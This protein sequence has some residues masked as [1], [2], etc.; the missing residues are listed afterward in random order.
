M[1][2]MT[3]NFIIIDDDP[4]SS[5]ACAKMIRHVFNEVDI[6]SFSDPVAGLAYINKTF[7]KASSPNAILLLDLAMP[8]M[9]GWDCLE[10]IENFG[11]AVTKYLKIYILSFSIDQLD[12]ERA[13]NNPL[14]L[15]Y[16]SKPI[17]QE[18]LANMFT[19]FEEGK[20]FWGEE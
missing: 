10:A 1:A 13:E 12:K 15:G 5:H 2:Y 8:V 20:H 14:V 19:D 6:Y 4:I 9:N 3:P 7:S 16:L 17:V 11:E 18:S